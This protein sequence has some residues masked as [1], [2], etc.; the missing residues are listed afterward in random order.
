M[1]PVYQAVRFSQALGSSALVLGVGVLLTFIF[2]PPLSAFGNMGWLSIP[3]GIVAGALGYG[4]V[5][6]V[7]KTFLMNLGSMRE[8]MENLS[9][10]FR[11]FSWPAI[12]VISLMAGLSEELLLRGLVQGWLVDFFN[13]LSGIVL[14]SLIFGLMHFLTRTYVIV[15]F[16]LGL[17][18]GV[19]YYL[20]D[21]LM[22]VIVAHAV[23]DVFAFAVLVKFPQSLGLRR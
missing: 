11:N 17:A 15:T 7:T 14:A 22:F 3:Y 16:I 20:S 5:F 9:S 10:L 18:F 12:L 8:L 23:Y 21:S 6:I 19:A 1:R 4:L 13:P 2:E